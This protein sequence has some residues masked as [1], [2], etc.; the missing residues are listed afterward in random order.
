[1]DKTS[2]IF[3]GLVFGVV[4]YVISAPANALMYGLLVFI[5]TFMISG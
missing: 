2:K 4:T 3:V 5:L 1:M